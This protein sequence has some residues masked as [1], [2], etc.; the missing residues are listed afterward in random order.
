MARGNRD[1][2]VRGNFDSTDLVQ[3]RAWRESEPIIRDGVKVLR[4]VL[5]GVTS[6][7]RYQEAGET[8]EAFDMLQL[9][10]ASMSEAA[11]RLGLGDHAIGGLSLDLVEDEVGMM[12]DAPTAERLMQAL[13]LCFNRADLPASR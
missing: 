5:L 10:A 4:P 3:R 8:D 1:S 2:A 11:R 9:G 13:R 7:V 12:C 6:V